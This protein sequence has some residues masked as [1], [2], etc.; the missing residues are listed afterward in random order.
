MGSGRAFWTRRRVAGA[1]VAVLAA[2]PL[3]RITLLRLKDNPLPRVADPEPVLVDRWL[4]DAS[5]LAEGASR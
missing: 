3:A 4:L 5:D 2:P 1:I